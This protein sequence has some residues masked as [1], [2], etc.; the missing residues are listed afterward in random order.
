MHVVTQ[1]VAHLDLFSVLVWGWVWDGIKNG[2]CI[3]LNASTNH[4]ILLQLFLHTNYREPLPFLSFPPDDVFPTISR[5]PVPFP[6]LSSCK[7]TRTFLISLHFPDSCVFVYSALWCF[8]FSPFYHSCFTFYSHPLLTQPQ[9]FV[10][11]LLD[12]GPFW[13]FWSK[14]M[15]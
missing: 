14:E 2:S 5:P 11:F 6:S 4:L 12:S 8:P 13:M 15:S 10:F 9:Y 3:S 1:E 7:H